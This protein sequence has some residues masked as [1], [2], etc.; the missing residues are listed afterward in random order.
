[1][2]FRVVCSVE[3]CVQKEIFLLKSFIPEM[4][5]LK[6]KEEEK[7]LKLIKELNGKKSWCLSSTFLNIALVYPK[8]P[9]D[10]WESKA[11]CVLARNSGPAIH[12]QTWFHDGCQA[13]AFSLVEVLASGRDLQTFHDF[14]LMA[15]ASWQTLEWLKYL[16]RG[17]PAP[18]TSAGHVGGGLRRAVWPVRHSCPF[19]EAVLVFGPCRLYCPSQLMARSAQAHVDK[20]PAG[21]VLHHLT[22]R[23]WSRTCSQG[24]ASGQGHTVRGAG[25]PMWHQPMVHEAIKYLRMSGQGA[26]RVQRSCTIPSA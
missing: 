6:R 12:A 1:M 8:Q 16:H 17:V 21:Q 13:P 26:H 18:T 7:A 25:M 23:S 19:R 5:V 4:Q 11:L 20:V 9:E 10:E 15:Q 14:C 2:K 22:S 3:N 24:E